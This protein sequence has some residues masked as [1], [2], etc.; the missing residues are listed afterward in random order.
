VLIVG[1]FVVLLI[2]ALVA[3][4]ALVTTVR[5]LN[6]Q[7]HRTDPVAAA[8]NAVLT[9]ALDQETGTRG[10]VITADASFLAPVANGTD[11]V[12][13]ALA[14]L[15]GPDADPNLAPAVDDM[16]TALRRWRT[17]FADLVVADVRRGDSKAA[18]SFV[19]SGNGKRLFDDFRRRHDV[20]QAEVARAVASN[21]K[22]LRHDVELSLIGLGAALG[23]G[24]VIAI[25][26]WLW[27]RVW[28]KRGA[29]R[30]QELAD[31]G[32][33]LRSV[34][35]ATTEPIFAKDA[36]GR[37]ILAN[38]ARAASLSEGN[39]DAVVLGRTVDDFVDAQMARAIREED[40]RVLET[41]EASRCEEVL[42]QPDGPHIFL[43]TKNPLESS[44]GRRI[45]IVGVARDVTLERLLH[46]D[47]ERLYQIEH[48]L[49]QTL[50]EAM[51][52]NAELDDDRMEVCARYQPALEELTVGGDWYDIVKLPNNMIG[53]IVGDAVG[54]GID[55]ATA[56]GQLRSALT[57]LALAGLDPA[58]ALEAVEAFAHTIPGA[59]SATCL[60]VIVDPAN[61]ELVYSVA[62]HMPPLVIAPGVPTRY[63]DDVQDPPL[64]AARLDRR[65]RTGRASFPAGSTLMLF[66]DGLVERRREPIDAGLDRL[67]VAAASAV[68]LPIRAMCDQL[69]EILLADQP[70]RDDVAVVAARL[71]KTHSDTFH[72]RFHAAG[73]NA[74]HVRHDF[75]DWLA[76]YELGTEAEADLALA[77]GEALANSVE[78]AYS[79]G[80][81]GIVDVDGVLT[82]GLLRLVVRDHGLWRAPHDDPHRGRG[83]M[84][85]RRLV[86]EVRV[87]TDGRGTAVTLEYRLR[88]RNPV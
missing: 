44:D 22:Q 53:L 72:R 36:E 21:R 41:G 13:T 10:Y 70:Q 69:I 4:P 29:E 49:A 7:Q 39:E 56:M 42:R 77:I 11:Q 30:D 59:H 8:T 85:M 79:S 15:H 14:T 75:Q 43:T 20:L 35:E 12:N 16:D 50:Q 83:M 86:D 67:A 74:R 62:G 19:Q 28:G 52:G 45:G 26:L 25:V 60:Y 65:R 64:A 82:D 84:L 76:Y 24:F 46:A 17:G 40:R 38:R 47:R 1:Y 48:R 18:Q 3:I 55:A 66:T 34:L 27:W 5:A 58:R 23:F 9:G 81:P 32:I 31:L 78:H 6:R 57:A 51:L 33:L 71:V 88:T 73:S 61:A 37:H 63:L 2:V 87:D 54:R 80:A 68:Q